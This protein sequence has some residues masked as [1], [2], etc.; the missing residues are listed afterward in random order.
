MTDSLTVSD[1]LTRRLHLQWFEGVAIVRSVT[2]QL[3]KRRAA[4]EH[5]PELH[6][7]ELFADGSV[8]ITGGVVTEAPVRRMGQLLQATL[9][10]TEIPVHLRLIVSQATAPLPTYPSVVELDAALAYVERPDGVALLRSLFVRAQAAD[11][12]TAETGGI[13]LDS[14]APLPDANASARPPASGNV[15]RSIGI[16]AAVIVVLALSG[17]AALYKRQT[18]ASRLEQPTSRVTVMADAVGNAALTA[19]S[20]VS[21]TVGLGRIVAGDATGEVVSPPAPVSPP[22]AERVTKPGPRAA[23]DAPLRASSDSVSPPTMVVYDD[24]ADRTTTAEAANREIGTLDLPA[25]APNQSEIYTTGAA[26]VTPPVGV[27]AQLPRQLPATVG[28]N[29]LV[30][31]ELIVGRDGSVESARLISPRRHVLGGMLLSAA[32]TWEFHPATREGAPV[33]F[34]KMILVSFE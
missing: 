27:G 13:T 16:A 6:Q 11:R 14:A 26:G 1:L 29:D 25:D 15:R 9:T 22:P 3:L 17:A 31:I 32:K 24:P 18:L 30:Q 12:L 4:A 19:M 5:I 20:V 21:D 23:G 10:D 28:S 34:R 8:A 2:T 33:R 7:I